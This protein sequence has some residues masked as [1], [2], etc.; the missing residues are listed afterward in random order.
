MHL[1][2]QAKNAMAEKGAD[3]SQNDEQDF[4]RHKF[5]SQFQDPSQAEPRSGFGWACSAVHSE[6]APRKR[7][8][9]MFH[10]AIACPENPVERPSRTLTWVKDNLTASLQMR[11]P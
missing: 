3:N 9:P 7:S 2:L 11:R 4:G 1:R 10:L 6:W 8:V 5:A